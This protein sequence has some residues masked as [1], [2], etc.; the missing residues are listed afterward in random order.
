[1]E[2]EWTEKQSEAWINRRLEYR[3]QAKRDNPARPRAESLEKEHRLVEDR[4]FAITTKNFAW[5][6]QKHPFI[7]C[8]APFSGRLTLPLRYMG[9]DSGQT[10]KFHE[11]EDLYLLIYHFYDSAPSPGSEGANFVSGDLL[12]K[13]HEYLG[14]APNVVGC[15]FDHATKSARIEW[16]DAYTRCFW[17]GNKIWKLETYFDPT[18]Q[19]WVSRPR[20]DF[21]KPLDMEEYLGTGRT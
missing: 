3:K 2:R 7:Q 18:V 5:E 1:M 16:W 20:G 12:T 8:I 14:P 9:D 19:G 13:R 4:L 10:L 17:I 11:G 21:D 6:L 15:R